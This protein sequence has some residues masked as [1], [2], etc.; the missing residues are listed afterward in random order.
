MPMS[1]KRIEELIEGHLRS[2]EPTL[3]LI[4]SAQTPWSGFLFER[5]VCYDGAATSILFPYTELVLVVAGSICV[6]YRAMDTD[7]HFVAREG[8]V[9]LWPAGYELS[10]LSWIA[11]RMDGSTQLLRIQLDMSV[12][13]P[14]APEDDPIA[15]V[16]LAPQSPVEDSTVASLM[17]LMELDVAA[18]CPAG[19]LYAQSLSLALAA[20]VGARY[21]TGSV[22][23]LPHDGLSRAVLTRVLDYICANLGRDLTITELASVANLSPHHFS[24]RFKRS[25][26]VAPH[27]WVVRTR[28]REAERLLKAHSMSVAEVA[29]AL[30]FASQTHFTDVFHR[31]TGTTPRQ[32]RRLC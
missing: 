23:T 17:R 5:S 27:Q 3:P 1:G 31:V 30:G 18:G 6:E 10:D 12:L 16:R 29:L 14:L 9:I 8:T 15:G 24:S 21:S 7:A 13:E 28:V 11:E 19:K 26:G 25:V 4:S 32:Y 2:A 22:G 20:H